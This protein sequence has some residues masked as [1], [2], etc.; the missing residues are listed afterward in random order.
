MGKIEKFGATYTELKYHDLW[1]DAWRTSD[2]PD[3]LVKFD[4]LPTSVTFWRGPSYGAG[5][6]TEQYRYA[7]V[8]SSGS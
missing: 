7:N 1:D 4:E 2:Y 8:E 3:I 6:V 5:W